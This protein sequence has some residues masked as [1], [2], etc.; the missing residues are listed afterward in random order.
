MTGCHGHQAQG[1]QHDDPPLATQEAPEARVTADPCTVVPEEPRRFVCR[2]RYWWRVFG[3]HFDVFVGTQ[4]L[5]KRLKL[6][7][8]GQ[9]WFAG[10][11]QRIPPGYDPR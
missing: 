2:Q 7:E 9:V 11:D 10:V 4:A 5:R 8:F 3:A 6:P 1:L